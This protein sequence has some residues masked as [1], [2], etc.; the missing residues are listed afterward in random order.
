MNQTT[1]VKI[2]LVTF[3]PTAAAAETT[4]IFGGYIKSFAI[5]QSAIEIEDLPTDIDDVDD[6]HQSQNSLRLM[7]DAFTGDNVAWQL[8]YEVTPIFFSRA[9]SSNPFSNTTFSSSNN[10][11]RLTDIK[12][13]ID[14]SMAKRVT[15]QNLDRLNARFNLDAGDLTIGRQVISLGSARMIN[16]IDV[17][18]P[19]KVTTLNQEYRTGVDMVR[20]QKPM[21]ELSEIDMGIVLGDDAKTENSA[22]FVNGQSNWKGSDISVTAIR[23]A[24]QNLLGGGIESSIGDMGVWFETAWVFGDDNYNRTSVGV[25][26]SFS[27]HVFGQIE[28]HYNGAGDADP[29]GYRDLQ[30]HVA[31]QKGGVFLLGKNYLMPSLS[32]TATP[33]LTL[34][35]S[36]LLNLDDSSAFVNASG[37]YSLGDELG[38]NFGLYLFYGDRLAYQP[39]PPAVTI[40]SEYGSNSNLAYISLNYFF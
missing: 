17:F 30:D 31:Y 5:A 24:E 34:T 1:F 11:Y 6:L 15:Y 9:A 40:Q 8:H 33:I 26:Y 39:A 38:M 4:F 3:I 37:S 25:D 14:D 12:P 13:T 10:N 2:L 7:A 35:V 36:S 22:V 28:Y 16:P 27:T 32:W 29:K 19:F 23:F 18:L 20:F 21:G